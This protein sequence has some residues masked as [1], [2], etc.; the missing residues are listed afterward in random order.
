MIQAGDTDDDG[1]AASNEISR[2]N[3][4]VRDQRRYR[5]GSMPRREMDDPFR[6]TVG[7][8]REAAFEHEVRFAGLRWPRWKTFLV[9]QASIPAGPDPPSARLNQSASSP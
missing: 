6:H 2:E 3:V 4:S 5:A 1:D 8:Q 7:L 9:K